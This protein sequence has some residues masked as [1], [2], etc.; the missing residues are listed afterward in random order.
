MHMSLY[1]VRMADSTLWIAGDADAVREF[2]AC[3]DPFWK[4]VLAFVAAARTAV[5]DR[6]GREH[7]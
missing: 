3:Y 7:R 2:D 4:S 1:I 5:H 6:Q